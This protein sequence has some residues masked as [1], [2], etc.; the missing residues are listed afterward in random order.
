M[1]HGYQELELYPTSKTS[2]FQ[3]ALGAWIELPLGKGVEG[4]LTDIC[5][6]RWGVELV[7][8]QLVVGLSSGGLIDWEIEEMGVLGYKLD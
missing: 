5:L 2:L 1:G 6:V 4:E 8:S 3:P 7:V